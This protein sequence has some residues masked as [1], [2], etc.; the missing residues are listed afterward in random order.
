MHAALSLSA[1]YHTPVDFWISLPLPELYTWSST[2]REIANEG[3]ASRQ[4]ELGHG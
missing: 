1:A 2:A 4:Q 3:A